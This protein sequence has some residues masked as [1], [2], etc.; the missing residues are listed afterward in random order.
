MLGALKPRV[1]GLVQLFGRPSHMDAGKAGEVCFGE[2]QSLR[3][4]LHL[5]K[6]VDSRLELYKLESQQNSPVDSLFLSQG[7]LP[8]ESWLRVPGSDFLV[9]A[10][11]SVANIV[12]CEIT[13][14]RRFSFTD[15]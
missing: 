7:I 15:S 1:R 8:P 4:Y 5:G 9:R 10:Q 2:G 13:E 12:K 3:S 14:S 6:V 11:E